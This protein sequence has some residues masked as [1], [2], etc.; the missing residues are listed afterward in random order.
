MCDKSLVSDRRAV[1][2]AII[3][4]LR[5]LATQSLNLWMPSSVGPSKVA[6]S[7]CD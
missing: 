4:D 2:P 7:A 5:F 3:V 1:A 6:F